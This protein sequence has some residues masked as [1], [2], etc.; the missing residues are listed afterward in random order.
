[1]LACLSPHAQLVSP[2]FARMVFR[3]HADMA[4]IL[5]AA[6]SS[7]RGL[8]WR[9]HL[10]DGQTALAISEAR[11]WGLA[12]TDA[13]VLEMGD[14]GR[15]AEIRPHLRPLLPITVFAVALGVKLLTHPAVILRALWPTSGARPR[16][17]RG[18]ADW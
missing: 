15:I 8:R 13:M 4:V 2:L 16:V 10:T 14:D 7:L 3:G 12:L 11:V 5:G 1:M 17:G 9:Q 6:F 18:D